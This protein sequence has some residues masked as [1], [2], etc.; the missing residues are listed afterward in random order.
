VCAGRRRDVR[1]DRLAPQG[2]GAQRIDWQK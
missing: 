1:I 2:P